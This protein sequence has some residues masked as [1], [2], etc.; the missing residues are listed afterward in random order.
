[1]IWS[2]L[3]IAL[4]IGFGMFIAVVFMEKAIDNYF[5]KNSL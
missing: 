4:A 5:N 2:M 3:I 1:M